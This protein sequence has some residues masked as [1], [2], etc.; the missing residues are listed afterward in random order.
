MKQRKKNNLLLWKG[1][2]SFHKEGSKMSW[3]PSF[4]KEWS[5]VSLIPS[6]HKE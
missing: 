3:I 2:G 4:Y 6:F 5:K 1:G